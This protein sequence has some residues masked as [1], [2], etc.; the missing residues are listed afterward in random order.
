MNKRRAENKRMRT[1]GCRRVAYICTLRLAC[2]CREHDPE[3][4]SGVLFTPENSRRTLI[5]VLRWFVSVN[6]F[7]AVGSWADPGTKLV[8]EV[9]SAKREMRVLQDHEIL[10]VFN[11]ISVGRW[12]VSEEK[13]SG[14]GKTPVGDFRIAWVKATGEFGPF[15]GIDYPSL[16]RGEKGLAA[17]EISQAE[18]DAIQKAHARGRVPPQGTRLGGYIG[19]HG[20]GAADP[21]IHHDMN[22]TRGCIAVTNIEMEQLLKWVGVGTIVKID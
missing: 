21:D 11:P 13:L 18:F 6:L 3:R 1:N 14:D 5:R 17:D 4:A 2:S 12:G 19:I 10:A 22:W 16:A 7:V 20:L 15:L 9:D 8:V